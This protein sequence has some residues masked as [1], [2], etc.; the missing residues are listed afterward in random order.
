MVVMLKQKYIDF[1]FIIGILILSQYLFESFKSQ[2]KIYISIFKYKG[3]F[4]YENQGNGGKSK[5]IYK[6]GSNLYLNLNNFDIK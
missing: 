6:I 3:G 5:Y 1:R 4:V 2:N